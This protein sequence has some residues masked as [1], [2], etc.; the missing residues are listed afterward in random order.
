[1]AA[2]TDWTAQCAADG[3][4]PAVFPSGPLAGHP[5]CRFPNTDGSGYTY[6]NYLSAGD[7]ISEL[8]GDAQNQIDIAEGNLATGVTDAASSV[9]D[10]LKG[11]VP[12][13]VGAVLGVPGWVVLVGAVIV[14]YLWAHKQ[15][16]I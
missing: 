4:T 1:M 12:N 8:V 11:I 13:A 15:G 14:G 7:T 5:A 3:G 6:E 10:T 16:L 2:T 9:Q